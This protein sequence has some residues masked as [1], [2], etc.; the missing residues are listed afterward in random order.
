MKAVSH[1]CSTPLLA[2]NQGTRAIHY[3]QASKKAADPDTKIAHA[4]SCDHQTG[5]TLVLN[6]EKLDPAIKELQWCEDSWD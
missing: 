2:Q 4:M 5:T 6:Q 1:G 3:E